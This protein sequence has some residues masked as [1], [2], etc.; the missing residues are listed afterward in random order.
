[1]FVQSTFH[2][3]WQMLQ[4]SVIKFNYANLAFDGYNKFKHVT[5]E[6]MNNDVWTLWIDGLLFVR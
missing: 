4:M 1:M 6:I 5:W 2:L 3:G